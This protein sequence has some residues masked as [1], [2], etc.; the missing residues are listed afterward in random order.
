MRGQVRS[1]TPHHLRTRTH[2]WALPSQTISCHQPPP[3]ATYIMFPCLGERTR[4]RAADYKSPK[5]GA[6]G[7]EKSVIGSHRHMHPVPRIVR[8]L[9]HGCFCNCSSRV[10]IRKYGAPGWSNRDVL[11]GLCSVGSSCGDTR[12]LQADGVGPRESG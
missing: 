3:N 12:K 7:E 8:H 5:T 4:N 10:G 1:F 9:D 11:I 6:W 2:E